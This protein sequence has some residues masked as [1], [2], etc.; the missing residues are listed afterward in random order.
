M[1]HTDETDDGKFQVL[2]TVG[3]V[4]AADT[5]DLPLLPRV[6]VP[7]APTKPVAVLA[8]AGGRACVYLPENESRRT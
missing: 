5:A 6:A 1:Q 2:A 7:G 3:V 4:S 8:Y